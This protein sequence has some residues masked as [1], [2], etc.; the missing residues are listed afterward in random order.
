MK[1]KI[2]STPS[3]I[4]ID[5]TL[6]LNP[7]QISKPFPQF[8]FTVP[9]IASRSLGASYSDDN[10]GEQLVSIHASFVESEDTAAF[11]SLRASSRCFRF[12]DPTVSLPPIDDFLLGSGELRLLR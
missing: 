5:G 11:F 9:R 2:S 3:N 10:S 6:S 12:I 1:N 8:R 7:F 4:Y